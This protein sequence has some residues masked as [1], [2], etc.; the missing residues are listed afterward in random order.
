MSYEIIMKLSTHTLNQAL[1]DI[2][3]LLSIIVVNLRSVKH[4]H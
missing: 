4:G 2:T 1:T 3:P